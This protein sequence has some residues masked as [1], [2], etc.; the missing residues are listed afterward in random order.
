MLHAVFAFGDL[1]A[2]QVMIPRT[3]M[4]CIQADATLYEALDL[5]A[6]TLLTKFPVYEEDLDH[7]IGILHTKDMVKPWHS[8]QQGITVRKLTREAIFLPESIAVDD[9]LSQ[10]RQ[11]RQHI[12]ILLDEYAG[13]AGLV[14][15]EDLME[16]LVGDV[17]D[18]F[19]RP[20]PEIQRLPDGSILIDGLVPIE[21]VNDTLGLNLT[22]PNYNT[23]AGYV[24][25]RLGR[26][27]AVGDVVQVGSK[28]RRLHF[29]V[30]KMDGLRIARLKLRI[31]TDAP[32]GT[33]E[34]LGQ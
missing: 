15:L 22:D 3:E 23:I 14:T 28:K 12:A 6:R 20:E 31:S 4:A 24:L 30:E 19:D 26:I 17:R 1:V 34:R 16:E 10:F 11:R 18:A 29:Q 7:I 13:T 32:P 33:Q 8:G 9:L 25:G 21:E 5:A 27:G 2:R